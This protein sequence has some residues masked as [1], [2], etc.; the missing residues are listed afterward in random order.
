MSK[1]NKPAFK[2]RERIETP[3][4]TATLAK[5]SF[6]AVN[7]AFALVASLDF[8]VSIGSL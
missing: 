3:N 6:T 1:S 2:I 5:C 8:G 4:S 7:S